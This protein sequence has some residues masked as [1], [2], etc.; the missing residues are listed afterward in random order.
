MAFF[1]PITSKD[2][3]KL[4]RPA[5]VRPHVIHFAPSY[6]I[7]TTTFQ[8]AFLIVERGCDLSSVS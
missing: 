3:F 6:I 8:D 2:L 7:V 4:F 1:I 5:A